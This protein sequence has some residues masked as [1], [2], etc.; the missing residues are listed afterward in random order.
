MMIK[1]GESFPSGNFAVIGILPNKNFCE[2][3][4]NNKRGMVLLDPKG[5]KD[6]EV[7]CPVCGHANK[8]EDM[9][10]VNEQV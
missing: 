9:G 2:D 6:G 10:E 4:A 5:S 8:I 3:C 7:V 1:Q